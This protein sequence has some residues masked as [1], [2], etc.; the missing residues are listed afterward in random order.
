MPEVLVESGTH[1]VASRFDR[2]PKPWL[3]LQMSEGGLE[4]LKKRRINPEPEEDDLKEICTHT[5]DEAAAVG[6]E[7]FLET[8][9]FLIDWKRSADSIIGCFKAWV[10]E[11][12]LEKQPGL[13]GQ[14]GWLKRL[15]GYR[16]AKDAGMTYPQAIKLLEKW[17]K[18][19][20]GANFDALPDSKNNSNWSRDVRQVKEALAGD[21][22]KAI[23]L[24]FDRLM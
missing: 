19:N 16:L 5:V 23:R 2:F 12:H 24:D 21:F 4:Y 3:A 20:Q 18:A 22:I 6:V 8:H 13:R 15:C 1:T 7:P 17:R 9:Y 11:R 10:N 14:L